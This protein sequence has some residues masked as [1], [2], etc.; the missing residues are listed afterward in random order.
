MA[1]HAQPRVVPDPDSSVREVVI[2]AF[3]R[4]SVTVGG[5]P[6]FERAV[7]TGEQRLLS[8]LLACPDHQVTARE[9]GSILWPGYLERSR[10]NSF[11]V[12]LHHVRRTLEP[13][14]Q[15]GAASRY[16]ARTGSVYRLCVERMVCDVD[17][18]TRLVMGVCWP[19][20]E[21]AV[22]RL[23]TAVELYRGDFLAGERFSRSPAL[24]ALIEGRRE[25][26]REAARTCV[27]WLEEW[28][29]SVGRTPPAFHLTVA[30]CGS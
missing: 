29:R 2:R 23:E 14:L 26:L 28:Y 27:A 9:A 19:L 7:P 24:D 6:V 1:S 11:H 5:A 21:D 17:L 12:V 15:I 10:A 16:V 20:D 13:D 18:F 30:R 22:V 25:Q 8:L 3:G 4:L